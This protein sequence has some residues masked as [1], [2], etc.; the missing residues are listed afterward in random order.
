MFCP[1]GETTVIF[2]KNIFKKSLISVKHY[3]IIVKQFNFAGVMELAD[4]VDSKST[5]GDTVP[6]RVRPPAPKKK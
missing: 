6:V 3:C 2:L 4:V 1:R 5:G